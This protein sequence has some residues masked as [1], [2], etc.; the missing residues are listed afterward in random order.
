MPSASNLLKK[1]LGVEGLTFQDLKDETYRKRFSHYL[2]W[3]TYDPETKVYGC[4]DDSVGFIFECSP[5]A[6]AGEQTME[7]LE[8]LVRLNVPSGS[9]IQFTLLADPYIE[10]YLSAYKA[11]KTRDSDLTRASA[12]RFTRFLAEGKEGLTKLNNIPVRD[13][14]LIV[15]AKFPSGGSDVDLNDTRN[16]IFEILS[17]ANLFPALM[18]A[19]D[20]IRWMRRLFNGEDYGEEPCRYDD[21]LPIGEQII[22]AETQVVKSMK[23]MWIGGRCFRCATPKEVPPEVNTVQTNQI[24]GGVWGIQQ[25]VNQYRTPFLYTLNIIY[26]DLRAWL[27]TKCN[28]MLQQKGVGSFARQ[29]EARK[30]EH[31]WAAGELEA[32]KRFVKVMPILWVYGASRD[33]VSESL[34]RAKRLWE[35]CGYR[36]QEDRGI[37]PIMFISS[38][39]LGLYNVGRN[40]DNLERSFVA[41][42]STVAVILPVQADFAGGGAPYLLLAGRKGQLCT[43]DLFDERVNNHNAFVAAST[44]SGKSFFVNCLTYNYFG[45]GAKIRIIDIG[46]S[47]KKMTRVCNARYLDFT[48]GMSI[49]P[50]TH[51]VDPQFDLPVIAQVAAQMCYSTS[52]KPAPT[53]IEMRLL[54]D[55]VTWA[56]RT[57]EEEAEYHHVYEFLRTYPE[58]VGAPSGNASFTTELEITAHRLAFAMAEFSRDG[59]YGQYFNGPSGFNIHDDEFVVLELGHLEQQ[60]QLFN[61]AVL[62]VINAVTSDFYRSRKDE[63]KL[64]AFDE[65]WQLIRDNVILGKIIEDGYRKARKHSGSFNVITQSATDLSLFGR[66]G[67][68]IDA[69]SAFKFFL[70]ADDIEKVVRDGVLEYGEFE[71]ALLKSVRRN[72]PKY[73]EIF[74]DTPFGTGVARLVVDDFSRYLYSSSPDDN[75]RIEAVMEEKGVDYREAIEMIL[76]QGKR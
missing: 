70:Q 49:N 41:P 21:S 1:V 69:N 73:S 59:R 37:L 4:S 8:G 6:F 29:H 31:M 7:T 38:L 2:P 9:V 14:R 54:M 33:A 11:L 15:S 52:E 63:K 45:A 27:H 24:F 40:V 36:M 65:G 47:Y 46:G 75:Q 12:E 28:A 16:T 64:V 43:L 57:H 42:A 66:V 50:F 35:D 68:V 22:F 58:K 62:Q 67:K 72:S 17:G 44:G 23:E 48:D 56:Y 10:P 3:V 5:L 32:G 18:D 25:D 19:E 13:F 76:D 60:K 26:S 53:E 39:P 20:L 71:A 55:A 61:V 34:V 51:I 30:E 74:L